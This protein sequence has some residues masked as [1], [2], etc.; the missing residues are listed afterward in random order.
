M[1]DDALTV[2]QKLYESFGQ[3]DVPTVMS[4]LDEDIDW[5]ES[6]GLP[7]GGP[8]RGPQ[9]VVEGV[10]GPTMQMVPDFKVTAQEWYPSGDTVA[11][12]HRYTGTGAGTGGKLD[13]LGCGVWTV[14]D[15]K[16]V[17][18]LQFVDTVTF[19]SAVSGDG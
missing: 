16:I 17:R 18:Y 3:G 2:V 13:V 19:N 1:A 5:Q 4:L 9:A 10:F 14:R 8:M 15:G 11:V 6:A 7:W 12:V